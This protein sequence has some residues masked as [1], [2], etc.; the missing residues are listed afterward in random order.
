MSPYERDLT[1]STEPHTVAYGDI[2]RAAAPVLEP[3]AE[4]ADRWRGYAAAINAAFPVDPVADA[5]LD[6]LMAKHSNHA[7][8]PLARRAP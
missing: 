5:A 6:A 7:M 1:A 3:I 8:R 4:S 2:Y